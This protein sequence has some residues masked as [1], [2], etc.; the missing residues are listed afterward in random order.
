MQVATYHEPCVQTDDDLEEE[1]DDQ[2]IGAC[3][4]N[5]VKSEVM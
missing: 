4:W 2:E 3:D 5:Y 1:E